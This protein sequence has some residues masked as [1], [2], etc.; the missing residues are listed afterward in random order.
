MTS[1]EAILHGLAPGSHAS[2]LFS[3]VAFGAGA[4]GVLLLAGLHL[5]EPDLAPSWHMVSEYAIGRHGWLMTACFATLAIGSVA[6][7]IGLLPHTGSALGRIGLAFLLATAC[8]Y[9]LAAIF[10]TDPISVSPEHASNAAKLHAIAFALGVPSFILA[11][12]LVSF[13]LAGNPLWDGVRRALFSFAHLNW[14]GLVIMIAIIATLLPKAGGFGPE[15]PV[16]WP[17]RL[18]FITYFGWIMTAAWPLARF[19]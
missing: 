17:N 11:S 12:Q 13:A 4:T 19:R 2:Q 6:L 1:P 8:G 9:A 18:M 16:G 14:I 3:R 10:P 5:A 7:T 15:V